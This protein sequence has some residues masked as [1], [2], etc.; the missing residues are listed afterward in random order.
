MGGGGGGTS[1]ASGGGGGGTSGASGGGGGGSGA[2]GTGASGT[3]GGMDA[4]AMAGHDFDAGTDPNRN[5]V[6]AGKICDRLATILCASE[7]ACC[8]HPRDFATCKAAVLK[9]C[10]D[11]AM[12]DAVAMQ[13][14]A[15]FDTD[16]AKTVFTTL[17]DMASK[18]DVTIGSFSDSPDGLR[19]IFKGT[20]AANADCTPVDPL[21]KAMAGGALAS[22]MMNADYACLPAVAPPWKC[23]ARAD[24]GGN[25]FSDVNC[26]P[27]LYC[28]NPNLMIS[29][30]NKCTA[31]KAVG[32]ACTGWNECMTLLC[33]SGKCADDN[34]Q[35]QYCGQE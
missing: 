19:K 28:D 26:K 14:A 21:N 35:N 8:D 9:D 22:C 17:E 20:K 27:G 4:G 15:G 16:Q 23:A 18:C 2:G 7:E 32:A 6:T 29:P 1:G 12:L 10:S 3:G 5:A 11:D 30:A 33:K 25:C 13:A 34:Q 24:T 31:R